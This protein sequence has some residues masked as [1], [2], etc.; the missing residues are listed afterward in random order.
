MGRDVCARVGR[1]WVTPQDKYVGM[2]RSKG[3]KDLSTIIN[4]DLKEGDF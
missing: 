4:S 3:Y 1:G 2:Y